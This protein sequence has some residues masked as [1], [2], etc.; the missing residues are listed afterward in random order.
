MDA[1]LFENVVFTGR[2]RGAL[3]GHYR[4]DIA[5]PDDWSGNQGF[6]NANR[7]AY[8]SIPWAVH[9]DSLELAA[10]SELSLAGVPANKVHRGESKFSRVVNYSEMVT[11]EEDEELPDLI[12][13]Y[14]EYMRHQN[15]E[16][17]VF[18]YSPGDS[19]KTAFV[20]YCESHGVLV[21]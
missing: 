7:E 19:N 1:C 21:D 12:G 14:V 10:K 17:F 2:L 16:D 9:V 4:W 20:E 13:F 11:L 3:L 5:K 18:S 6:L 15:C 8:E